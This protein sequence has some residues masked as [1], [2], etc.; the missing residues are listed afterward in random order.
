MNRA[1]RNMRNQLFVISHYTERGAFGRCRE[2]GSDMHR[3]GREAQLH[4]NK[5]HHWGGCSFWSQVAN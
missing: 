4:H 2:C 1:R 5:N 3:T